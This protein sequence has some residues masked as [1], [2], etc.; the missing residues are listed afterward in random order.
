MKID[1]YSIQQSSSH[2]LQKSRTEKEH[3]EVWTAAQS[4]EPSYIVDIKNRT[5]DFSTEKTC[6]SNDLK[7][8][9][10]AQKDPRIKLI[11]SFV[12]QLTGK[13]I[14]FKCEA[15]KI[16]QN[17]KVE[18]PGITFVVRGGGKQ[19]GS[20]FGMVYEYQEIVTEQE[21]VKFNSGGYVTT[22]DG[23]TIAFNLEFE[24]SR[25]FYM[26]TN[27][28][29]RLGDAAKTVDPLVVVFGNGTP[30]L[31]ST[32]HAFDLTANGTAENISFATGNSGFLA[33]D[34]NSDGIINDGTE[35][36]GP[37]SGNGFF[38][39]RQ[40]DTDN[41]GWIDENDEVFGQLLLLTM[42]SDGEKTL[43]KLGDVG[44]GA[45]YLNDI[46]TQFSL[47][48]E[49]QEY[50]EMKSSSVFLRENGTAGTIHH[51]DLSI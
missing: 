31:T 23:R 7:A 14:K 46:S 21:N 10:E 4:D 22:A 20:G 33:L 34:K 5:Y 28:S 11:E 43:F 15:P 8:D 39:L 49:A 50:G 48:D 25:S 18:T 40:Y 13:R 1:N 6:I 3:L 30:T 47:K 44:I 35:L 29:L 37:T 26:Q 27:L 45:I 32:K 12:Y 16:D 19:D 42:T 38:E 24:M 36:F 9:E 2:N 51:I 17:F 41:N